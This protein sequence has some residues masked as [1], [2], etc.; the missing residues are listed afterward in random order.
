MTVATEVLSDG[1][2]FISEYG[3]S[4]HAP[5]PDDSSDNED[6]PADPNGAGYFDS[7]EMNASEHN[8][9]EL[10]DFQVSAGEVDSR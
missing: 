6:L 1:M 4:D 7:D 5:A 9:D 10:D 8:P 2:E 3:L